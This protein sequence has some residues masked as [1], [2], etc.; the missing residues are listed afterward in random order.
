MVETTKLQV[1]DIEVRGHN[2]FSSF[3]AEVAAMLYL[4]EPP[5]LIGV[6]DCGHCGESPSWVPYEGKEIASATTCNWAAQPLQT[7]TVS[8]PSGEIAFA[9]HLGARIE[10]LK[11]PANYNSKAGQAEFSKAM[12]SIGIAYGAVGNTSP[13]VYLETATGDILVVS[14]EWSEEEELLS[15]EGWVM[16]GEICTDLWAYSIMDKEA[17]L[18]HEPIEGKSDKYVSFAKVQAGTYVFTHYPSAQ[19]FDPED[20]GLII[21]AR[22]K[23]VS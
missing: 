21:F 15:P 13:S 1:K 9:D 19:N 14:E 18:S 8:F 6:F 7:M 22:G 20:D 2:Y 3:Q 11:T 16:L 12:E 17:Y 4:G 23:R 5:W 10:P